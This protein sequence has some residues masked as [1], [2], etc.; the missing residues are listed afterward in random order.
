MSNGSPCRATQPAIPSPLR[1]RIPFRRSAA[2]DT[3]ISKVS[4]SVSS[5][6]NSRDHVWGF[7]NTLTFS[8]MTLRTSR[9]SRL[10][11]GS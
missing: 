3:A 5:S 4:S 11:P 1:S 7:N 10:P 8:M 2:G 6:S 9:R